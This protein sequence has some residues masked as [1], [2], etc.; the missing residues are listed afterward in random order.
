LCEQVDEVTSAYSLC[1]VDSDSFI[2]GTKD[3]VKRFRFNR[4]GREY[5]RVAKSKKQDSI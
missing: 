4:P 5:Q 3:E 2:A 1:L